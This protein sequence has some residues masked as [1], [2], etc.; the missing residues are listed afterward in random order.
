[1]RFLLVL[2]YELA[3]YGYEGSDATSTT[4]QDKLVMP[5]VTYTVN[6]FTNL[7]LKTI[8]LEKRT[9]YQNHSQK[10]VFSVLYSLL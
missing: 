2:K 8:S 6:Q 10:Q 4:H 7:Q 9:L 5:V 1:M 3:D